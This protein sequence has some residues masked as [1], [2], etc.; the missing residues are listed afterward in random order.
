MRPKKVGKTMRGSMTRQEKIEVLQDWVEKNYI[1]DAE[2]LK[3]ACEHE[4]L[5]SGVEIDWFD[6]VLAGLEWNCCDRCGALYP[7]EMLYWENC[8]WGYEN[9]DLVKGISKEKVEYMALCEGCASELIK[10]G[11]R[12]DVQG[13]SVATPVKVKVLTK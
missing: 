3:Q 13:E 11:R 12:I 6:D 4:R 2:H 9:E 10:K 5:T 7:S 8:D 1:T